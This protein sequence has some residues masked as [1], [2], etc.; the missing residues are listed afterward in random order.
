MT[1]DSNT[2][3]FIKHVMNKANA[4][5]WNKG[6]QVSLEDFLKKFDQSKEF[7]LCDH[8]IIHFVK[9]EMKSAIAECQE[10]HR[11]LQDQLKQSR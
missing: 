7:G 11:I 3:E 2:Q 10:R 8:D 1:Q 6:Y 9:A 4:L 5:N